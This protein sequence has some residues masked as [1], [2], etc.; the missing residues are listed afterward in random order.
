M[1]VVFSLFVSL[2]E[3]GCMDGNWYRKYRGFTVS[4]RPHSKCLAAITEVV[5]SALSPDSSINV[6]VFSS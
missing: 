6:L 3:N 1:C 5:L 2:V 4:L